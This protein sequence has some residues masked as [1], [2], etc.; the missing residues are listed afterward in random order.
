MNME[1]T[2]NPTETA[3]QQKPKRKITRIPKDR[4]VPVTMQMLLEIQGDIYTGKRKSQKY[5]TTKYNH[6]TFPTEWM[7][8]LKTVTIDVEYTLKFIERM[9]KYRQEYNKRYRAEK[10]R[11]AALENDIRKA[12]ATAQQL[13]IPFTDVPAME[14]G[15]IKEETEEAVA[16]QEERKTQLSVADLNDVP[17]EVLVMATIKRGYTVSETRRS[18]AVQET[19]I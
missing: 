17:D 19:D 15:T 9:R 6:G 5:Y 13:S 4:L 12:T 1:A 18:Y 7:D 11:Q 10:L 16:R 14:L 2:N 3:V 8:E